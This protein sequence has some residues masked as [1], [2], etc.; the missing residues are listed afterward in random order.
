MTGV[1]ADEDVCSVRIDV[2][3]LLGDQA[4]SAEHQDRVMT[5]QDLIQAFEDERN[6]KTPRKRMMMVNGGNE[7]AKRRRRDPAV[8][9]E[10]DDMSESEKKPN[11]PIDGLAKKKKAISLE[12]KSRPPAIVKIP[13]AYPCIIC[14]NLGENDLLPVFQP[15]DHVK[16]LCKS[17]DRV[18]RAHE[19]C[20]TSV[21]EVWV[22]DEEVDG[23]VTSVVM[24]MNLIEKSR[25]NLVRITI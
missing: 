4:A 6:G 15:G 7:S 11:I 22:D 21:P 1:E 20:V 12:K 18:V 24:G 10:S 17:R 23:V 14:P 16:A 19:S 5:E 3:E 9:G 13:T 2:D 25:W 8:A